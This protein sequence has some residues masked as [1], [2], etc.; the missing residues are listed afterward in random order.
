MQLNEIIDK[1]G[2][3]KISELTN[4][5]IDNLNKLY[6]EDFANLT[7]VKSLGF[8]LIL[9]RDYP[10]I[11]V[12][13]LRERVKAYYEEHK[14]VD[15]NVVM[16]SKDSVEGNNFSFFK[17]F[18]V[19]ALFAGGLYLYTQG[20]LDG[21]LKN[22]EEKEDFFD[23]NKALESN[24]T[25]Q[26]AKNV[27]I[28]NSKEE[29]ISIATPVAPTEKKITL[30]SKEHKNKQNSTDSGR[31]S[32]K[33]LINES[34]KST[35]SVVQE[36]VKSAKDVVEKTVEEVV[37]AE[38]NETKKGSIAK[39]STITINPT[40][41]TLWFGFINIDTKKKREFMKKT[42]TPFD[43]K[44]GRWLLVTG[45]GYVDIVSDIKTLEF[46]DSKKHYFYIDSTE[47]KS[48]SKRE[49][50]AMNGRRGW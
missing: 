35:E 22:V 13:E 17:W 18:I 5:S 43:I 44:G 16:V 50:R 30:I 31:D 41:G 10:G 8:L 21:L 33:E 45:H 23:D 26:E 36:V 15:D 3:E 46:A 11:D 49:F 38:S 14:P 1:D 32:S 4:I 20:K 7:R 12:S 29:Q 48:L 27:V 39:I 40:R 42:S 47:I 34:Q 24:V 9:E 6:N 2:V 19:L 28:K 37:T 25:E